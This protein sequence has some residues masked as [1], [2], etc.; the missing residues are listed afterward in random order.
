MLL[1]V[2]GT[3]L[4]LLAFAVVLYA[5]GY[6]FAFATDLFSF[7]TSTFAEQSIW[8]I[9][10][11]FSVVPIAVYL[12]GRIAG[13]NGICWLL[14]AATLCTLPL[15]WLSIRHYSWPTRGRWIAVIVS[16]AWIALALLLLIDFQVGNKLY[17]SVVVADQSY[18]VA[19]T[20][21]VLRT[22]VPPSN[23]LYFDG[24]VAPMRYYYFWYVI[25]AT[26]AKLAHVSSR[27]AFTASSIAAGFG[28]IATV[29]L[30]ATHFFRWNRKG[31]WIALGLLLVTGADLLPALGNAI[32]RHTLSGDTEWWS[33]DPIDAW[34][35][36]LLWVP[37]HVASAL[38]CLLSL[39]FLWRTLEP[40]HRGRRRWP[41]VIAALA[42][43]SAFGLSIYVACGFALLILAWLLW[44]RYSKDTDRGRLWRPVAVSGLLSALV[45]VPFLY[46]VVH[47]VAASTPASAGITTAPPAPFLSL[48]VRQIIDPTLLSSLPLF[49]AWRQ[50]HP[51]LL[52]QSLRLV[53]LLPGLAL[54]LGFFGIVLALLLRA[55]WRRCPPPPSPALDTALFFAICGLLIAAFISSSVITNNDFG[56][57]VVMLP[58]FFL[59]LLAADLLVSWQRPEFD[60][61]PASTPAR[62]RWLYSSLA[63]GIAGSLY[64]AFLLRAWLPIEHL[65]SQ[66]GFSQLPEDAFQLRSLFAQ[67][68][69]T[70][71][72]AAVVAFR[73][74]D[75]LGDRGAVVITPNELYQRLIVMNVGRQMLNAER[76]CATHFG[77][78]PSQC[79]AIRL[80]T[81][82]LYATPSPDATEARLFCARFG[83]DYLLIGRHDTDW[84]D[85]SGWPVTLPVIARQPGYKIL[86]CD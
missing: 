47:N 56:Y 12:T 36:S 24:S 86:Q 62:R 40:T 43:A 72:P 76:N 23:P 65:R 58:Q 26:V 73:P 55:K 39:L 66:D 67:F 8:A 84:T 10:C 50:A 75:P 33:V 78:N 15:L 80:S 48:S 69:S 77:G 70:A 32:A 5:P 63:L 46:E 21:A 9:A 81:D 17:F 28:L 27:Q 82:R 11:S 68:E 49:A 19:F 59:T 83:V 42:F 16:L 44:L 51:V 6:L 18:R 4:A 71:P 85:P 45:L 34:P 25:C 38:C 41:I 61:L 14:G 2:A 79:A 13:L 31:Y 7:R 52:D 3:L 29:K 74:I 54:E 37:H 22:G 64:W 60:S 35:D 30:Y 20:D 1:D 53:L 57:R